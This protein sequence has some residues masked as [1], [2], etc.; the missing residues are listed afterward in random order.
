MFSRKQ[1]GAGAALRPAKA[2]PPGLSFFGPEMVIS[3]DVATGAQIHLDGRIDGN[4][5]C[6]Q[7]CQGGSGIIAGDIVADEARIAGLVE[8]TVNARTLIV[9]PSARVTGDVTYETISIAAG[10]RIDGRLARREALAPGAEADG[11]LIA[12]PTSPA[13]ADPAG[14]AELFPRGERKRLLA[15]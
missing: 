8:G 1:A 6:A 13:P 11:V 3:G 12:T 4:V 15:G 10:A 7:L 14:G 9:E 5:R 2:G